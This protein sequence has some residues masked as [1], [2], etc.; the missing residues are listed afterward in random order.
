MTLIGIRRDE[1]KCSPFLSKI[2]IGRAPKGK[3]RLFKADPGGIQ[4][5]TP[6]TPR[7]IS[8]ALSSRTWLASV[9]HGCN[10]NLCG[11]VPA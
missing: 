9:A 10:D 6:V 2:T 5:L 1:H 4:K 7:P 3:S 8:M 11:V